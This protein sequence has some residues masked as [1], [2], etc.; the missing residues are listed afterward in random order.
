MGGFVW[1]LLGVA[2]G[3]GVAFLY[4]SRKSDERVAQA[5]E[6]VAE[7]IRQAREDALQADQ[8]HAETKERL[9]AL[10][11]RHRDLEKRLQ[12][13]EEQ[14]AKAARLAAVASEPPAAGAGKAGRANS[15]R[16][17]AI[18]AKLAQLPAGSS[19]RARLERQRGRLLRHS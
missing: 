2:L 6:G 9:I 15:A 7:Q 10:Q 1:F 3:G 19:A 13:H 8:A 18:D 5:E 11:M 16:L 14:E 17:K 4:V 12:R